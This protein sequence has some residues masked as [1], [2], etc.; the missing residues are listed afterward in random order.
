MLSTW[1]STSRRSCFSAWS[2][3]RSVSMTATLACKASRSR[4]NTAMASAARFTDFSSCDTRSDKF[5]VMIALSS[6]RTLSSDSSDVRVETLGQLI[7]DLRVQIVDLAI[8][9]S[10]VRRLERQAPREASSAGSNL[11]SRVDVEQHDPRQE[12]EMHRADCRLDGPGGDHVAYDE[13]EVTLN[14]WISRQRLIGR[15]PRGQSQQR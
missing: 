10:A 12:R 14:R 8:S 13:G 3:P 9:E 2:S 11:V 15:N 6:P 7:H 5:S 4:L 1:L